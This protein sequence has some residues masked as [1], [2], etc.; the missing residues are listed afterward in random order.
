MTCTSQRVGKNLTKSRNRGVTY[1]FCLVDKKT[2]LELQVVHK[3]HADS[4]SKSPHEIQSRFV[5]RQEIDI[6][7]NGYKLQ[8]FD[9]YF[10]YIFVN[11]TGNTDASRSTRVKRRV[12]KPYFPVTPTSATQIF[13]TFLNFLVNK[14]Y[15]L[16]KLNHV[17]PHFITNSNTFSFNFFFIKL[18][19]FTLFLK[20]K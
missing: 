7:P 3:V 19:I 8:P 18:L 2:W 16:L 5:H 15:K 4:P 11:S 10:Q 14:V 12:R 1:I 20:F 9:H 17:S 6:L 13:L